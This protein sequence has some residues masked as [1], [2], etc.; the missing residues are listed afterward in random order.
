MPFKSVFYAFP[1]AEQTVQ[2]T[3]VKYFTPHNKAYNI[4]DNTE[5]FGGLNPTCIQ[6]YSRDLRK[7][8]EKIFGNCM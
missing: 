6:D 3:L 2:N 8:S 1:D 7:T 5:R 4:W